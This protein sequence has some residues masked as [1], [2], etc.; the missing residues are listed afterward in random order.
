MAKQQG[1]SY[2]DRELEGWKEAR[3]CQPTRECNRLFS[4]TCLSAHSDPNCLSQEHLLLMNTAVAVT[5][6]VLM[7]QATQRRQV[8]VQWRVC[9]RTFGGEEGKG[10]RS[11]RGTGVSF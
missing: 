3:R 7:I 9:V 6:T 2:T 4:V 8:V 5:M 10:L 1:D 11:A